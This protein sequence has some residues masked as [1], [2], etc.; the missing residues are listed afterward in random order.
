ME[1]DG[2]IVESDALNGQLNTKSGPD[3]VP[4]SQKATGL[5]GIV[6]MKTDPQNKPTPRFSPIIDGDVQH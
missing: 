3:Q 5:S 6:R 2:E 4:L 1:T